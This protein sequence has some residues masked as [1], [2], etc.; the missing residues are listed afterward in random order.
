V[1]GPGGWSHSLRALELPGK[2]GKLIGAMICRL[3]GDGWHHEDVSDLSDV[4]AIKGAA[5][6]ALKR[7]AVHL[8]IGRYLYELGD[9]WAEIHQNGNNWQP[10]R[11]G[12]YPSFRWDP[13][14]PQDLP[15]W[16]V[17]QEA[18]NPKKGK[19]VEQGDA[20]PPPPPPVPPAPPKADIAPYMQK[21]GAKMVPIPG[22]M[23]AAVLSMT[24]LSK[25]QMKYAAGCVKARGMGIPESDLPTW[26]KEW[27][28]PQAQEALCVLIAIQT[29]KESANAPAR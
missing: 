29:M 9:T 28:L 21:V 1:F 7:C 26:D 22:A 10:G 2:D 17:P 18:M 20:P 15:E 12:K 23:R 6:G 16:M 24:E 19:I 14:G 3:E 25:V 5:S 27:T 8:G 13:P 4:E 11:D